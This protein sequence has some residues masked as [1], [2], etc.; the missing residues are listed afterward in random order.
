MILAVSLLSC[1]ELITLSDKPNH[2]RGKA[3]IIIE[4][5]T[6]MSS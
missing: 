5:A 2:F 6:V 4:L 3:F 1:S